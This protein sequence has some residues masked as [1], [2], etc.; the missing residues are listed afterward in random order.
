MH[1]IPI[2]FTETGFEK[3]KKEYEE[4]LKN[5]KKAVS[6]LSTARDMGDRSEN[7]A[8][9]SARFKLSG[10][11]RRIRF[12]KKL[13]DQGV[14][15]SP[16]TVDTVE[17]GSS[18]TV[19]TNGKQ[20]VFDLVGEYEA[21]PMARKLSHKSPVGGLLVGKKVGDT[22]FVTTPGGVVKYKILKLRNS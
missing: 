21:D 11:D 22:V 12:L 18:V 17:I 5:R 2:P 8:Y 16:K 20:I 9:K 15:V 1:K 4:I 7:A 3:I 6:E 13:I 10:I 14:V 19:E